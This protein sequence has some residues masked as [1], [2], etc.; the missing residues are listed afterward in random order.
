MIDLRSEKKTWRLEGL[1][2]FEGSW[3]PLDG[4]YESEADAE[5]AARE[6][7]QHLEKTQPTSLSGGQF[8]GIQDRVFIVDP[9]GKRRRFV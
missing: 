3:Y 9:D 8:G 2:T 7:L 5:I 4:E 6:R 1:D